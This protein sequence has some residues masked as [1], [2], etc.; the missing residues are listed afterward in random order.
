MFMFILGSAV[1]L[2]RIPGSGAVGVVTSQVSGRA[3]VGYS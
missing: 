2:I 1:V 3:T